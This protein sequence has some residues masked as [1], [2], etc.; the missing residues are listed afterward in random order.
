ME[1]KIA[2][3]AGLGVFE[4]RED[5]KA[6]HDRLECEPARLLLPELIVEAESFHPRRD[7]QAFVFAKVSDH[8]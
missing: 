8:F 7:G 5:R 1:L 4:D 3:E 2:E 6:V